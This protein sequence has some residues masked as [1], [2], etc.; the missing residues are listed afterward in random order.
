[1][2]P[3]FSCKMYNELALLQAIHHQIHQKEPQDALP[4]AASINWTQ[5]NE[6]LLVD[7]GECRKKFE[8][9]VD[10]ARAAD[11]A[12]RNLDQLAQLLR[13]RR[14]QEVE[15]SLAAIQQLYSYSC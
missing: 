10:L 4:D 2:I 6:W 14:I 8:S 5:V 11:P 1:M 13:Y 15:A 3:F 12:P 7:A 9:L